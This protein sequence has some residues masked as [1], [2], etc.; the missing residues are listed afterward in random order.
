MVK[1]YEDMFSCFNTILAC[2][3][4]LATAQSALCIASCGKNYISLED[5]DLSYHILQLDNSS[6]QTG[7]QPLTTPEGTMNRTYVTQAYQGLNR[8]AMYYYSEHSNLYYSAN[9]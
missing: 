8:T 1:K 7:R 6:L 4:H 5:Q 2:Y 3:G 9:Q